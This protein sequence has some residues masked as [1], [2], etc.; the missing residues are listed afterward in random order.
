MAAMAAILDVESKKKKKKPACIFMAYPLVKFAR[1]S[2][3][4]KGDTERDRRTDRHRVIAITTGA[5]GTQ[6]TLLD[7]MNNN[8]Q[9]TTMHIIPLYLNIQ[10][11]KTT[12]IHF[13]H[14]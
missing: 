2:F 9:S 5:R 10:Q 11:Y 3:T 14:I 1:A 8:T 6:I 13:V 12:Y 4:I 7:K